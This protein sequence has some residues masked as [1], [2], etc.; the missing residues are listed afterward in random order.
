MP[1]QDEVVHEVAQTVA[2]SSEGS[3]NPEYGIWGGEAY[4]GACLPKDTNGLVGLAASIG[5]EVPLLKAAIA[6]NE[7]M[8]G[9]AEHGS[10]ESAID[11]TDHVRVA[12]AGLPGRQA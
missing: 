12:P 4:G 1:R 6:V 9:R 2:R 3:L 7:A 11:L 5:V 10:A 8:A